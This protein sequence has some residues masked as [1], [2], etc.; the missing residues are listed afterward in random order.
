[1]S[2]RGREKESEISLQALRHPV[3][4]MRDGTSE[5]S[6]SEKRSRELSQPV[7]QTDPMESVRSRLSEGQDEETEL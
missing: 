1:M 2:E 4:L 5:W 6:L 7:S 3:P